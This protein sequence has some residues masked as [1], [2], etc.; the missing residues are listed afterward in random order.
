M[1]FFTCSQSDTW[2]AYKTYAKEKGLEH[3]RIRSNDGAHIIRGIYHIQN[4]NNVYNRLKQ[5][6]DRFKGVA[7][8]YLDNDLASFLFV[9]KRG[10]ESTKKNIKDMLLSSFSFEM[11]D[12]FKSI[13]LSKFIV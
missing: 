11:N 4:V 10:H 2:R 9:D 12:T 6:I 1:Y 5:W 3:Y 8:K 13:R 7:S